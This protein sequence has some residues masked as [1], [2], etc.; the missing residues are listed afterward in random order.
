MVLILMTQRGEASASWRQSQVPE[1]MSCRCA[2]RQTSRAE[3]R[4][5]N[6]RLEILPPADVNGLM[7]FVATAIRCLWV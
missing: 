3:W 1:A 7:L 2:C 4:L 6:F 5:Q